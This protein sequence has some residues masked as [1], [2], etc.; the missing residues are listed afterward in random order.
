MTNIS[1]NHGQDEETGNW[2]Y[3]E[4]EDKNKYVFYRGHPAFLA[5]FSGLKCL[6]EGMEER[7]SFSDPRCKDLIKIAERK[8]IGRFGLSIPPDIGT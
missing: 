8:G 1:P 2:L 3:C 4:D 5:R 6:I 7:F